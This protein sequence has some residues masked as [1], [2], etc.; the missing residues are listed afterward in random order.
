MASI[1]C[2]YCGETHLTARAVRA[3][4]TEQQ[5]QL[6]EARA[7]AAAERIN[8]A[9][10]SFGGAYS[11]MTSYAEHIEALASISDDPELA[12]EAEVYRAESAS[13]RYLE[14]NT[15]A[16]YAAFQDWERDMVM[17]EQDQARLAWERGI[18]A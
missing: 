14:N 9:I 8:D 17:V 16:E 18:Y 11:Q 13:D 2:I 10:M 3:C 7:E 6:E 4:Y 5:V 1:K 12:W 15:S